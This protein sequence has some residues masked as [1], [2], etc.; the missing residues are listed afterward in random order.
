MKQRAMMDIFLRDVR[1]HAHHGVFEQERTV[2]NEFSVNL[3]VSV[4]QT[5]G[6][7][8][9]NLEGTLSYA[10]LY[11]AV[12]AEMAVPSRL[13][14]HLAIRTVSRLRKDFPQIL[15]GEIEITKIAPPI[16]GMRGEAGVALR[17]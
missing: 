13:L 6:M 1:F 10:D 15:S 5:S 7:A 16:P 3:R 11:D 14:E 2:G 12:A 17:F 4:E 9:D 8:D